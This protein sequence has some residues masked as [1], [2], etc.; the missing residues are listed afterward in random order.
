MQRL[1]AGLG[2]A[3]GA[4]LLGW[5]LLAGETLEEKLRSR[6]DRL[7]TVLHTDAEVG[8]NPIVRTASLRGAF[9]ELF[10]R[11]VSFRIP[12]LASD[13]RGREA[14]ARLATQATTSLTTLE[15][16]FGALAIEGT[17]EGSFANV[18]TRATVTALRGSQGYERDERAVRFTFD[19]ADGDW[20][21]ASVSVAPR[22]FPSAADGGEAE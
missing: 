8:N 18:R 6:L 5:A 4:A 3:A 12:E 22:E 16:D 13:D 1:L 14:L 15:V 2:F 9:A 10:T 19:R 20:L 7:E 17:L 11:D 21:I